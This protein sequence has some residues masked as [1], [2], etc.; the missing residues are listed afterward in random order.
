MAQTPPVGP[1]PPWVHDHEHNK[2]SEEANPT[3]PAIQKRR[4]KT[5]G[6]DSNPHMT[7]LRHW[8]FSRVQVAKAKTPSIFDVNLS[9]TSTTRLDKVKERLP[10]QARAKVSYI[11]RLPTPSQR[12]SLLRDSDGVSVHT[13]MEVDERIGAVEEGCGTPRHSGCR[14]P[15]AF[16]CPPAPKKKPVYFKKQAPP[17]NGYFQPPDLEALFAMAPI[18]EGSLC[19]RSRWNHFAPVVFELQNFP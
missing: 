16:A 8:S 17:K 7:H 12:Y 18:E 19:L 14:L 5:C 11:N 9:V 2:A 15:A 1:T 4:E 6:P 3:L 10:E 13:L